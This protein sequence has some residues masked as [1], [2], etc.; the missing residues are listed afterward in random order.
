[1][2]FCLV[3]NIENKEILTLLHPWFLSEW[4]CCQLHILY[5]CKR[6]TH[7]HIISHYK[8]QVIIQSIF[9]MGNV[10]LAFDLKSSMTL[11]LTRSWP[12]TSTICSLFLELSSASYVPLLHFMDVYVSTNFL[13]TSWNV[14]EWTS[15]M[16]RI[17]FLVN[18]MIITTAA[19]IRHL[20]EDEGFAGVA[21]THQQHSSSLV[22]ASSAG[23][24]HWKYAYGLLLLLQT[25]RHRTMSL[26]HI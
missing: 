17:C 8:S 25:Y 10:Y 5:L 2:Y 21:D 23:E 13:F 11:P 1:M 16:C 24:N 19:L 6:Q 3:T 14:C 4:Y 18:Y 22:W 12:G 26:T 15:V 20:V 7:T 9:C